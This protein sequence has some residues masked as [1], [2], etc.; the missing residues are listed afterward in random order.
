MDY[1]PL[2]NAHQLMSGTVHPITGLQSKKDIDKWQRVQQRAT[3]A[4]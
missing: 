4:E 3:K 1:T 2:A